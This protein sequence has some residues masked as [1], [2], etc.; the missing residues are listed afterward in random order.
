MVGKTSFEVEV[1][2]TLP[3]LMEAAHALAMTIVGTLAVMFVL[4][5]YLVNYL[6]VITHPPFVAEYLSP[7]G[8]WRP[9][10]YANESYAPSH[11]KRAYDRRVRH[12][13]TNHI[14]EVYPR[15]Q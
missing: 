2:H 12:I 9:Y 13:P 15:E 7:T 10:A 4:T 14:V 1:Q 3:S 6:P 8:Q 11:V 5:A